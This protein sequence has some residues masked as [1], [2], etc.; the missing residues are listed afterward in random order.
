MYWRGSGGL[1]HFCGGAWSSQDIRNGWI[2]DISNPREA[3]TVKLSLVAFAAAVVAGLPDTSY[4][5]TLACLPGVRA[6]VY[7]RRAFAISANDAK[8]LH[9][10]LERHA[11]EIG[12]S[13][14]SVGGYD[15]YKKPPL[16]SM[17]SILQSTSVATVIEVRTS[18]SSRYA[19]VTVGN[20]CFEPREDW[21]PYWQKFNALLNRL[22]YGI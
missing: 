21:R 20:N 4:A 15:P 16:R 9:L 3:V 13:Y 1:P 18:N 14:S 7:E 10:D 5:T 19:Q 2:A 12:L 22:G 8:R 17:D 6:H 11:G